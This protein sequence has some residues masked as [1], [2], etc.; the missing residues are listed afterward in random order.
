MRWEDICRK[1]ALCCHEKVVFPDSILI[2]LD[3]PCEHLDKETGLCSVYDRRQSACSRCMKVTPLRAMFASYLPP[4]CA[5]AEW[6]ER[7]HI[8]FVRKREMIF[9]S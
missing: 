2:D 7:H 1:C 9:T 8:R 6:A 4:V 5:Y 3:S